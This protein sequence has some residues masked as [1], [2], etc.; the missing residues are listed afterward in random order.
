MVFVCP[1]DVEKMLV[2]GARSVYWKKWAAKHEYEELREG[3]LLY[4]GLTLLRKKVKEN[5]TEKHRNVA[6][7]IFFGRRLDPKEIIR[8]WLVGC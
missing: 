7:K 2:Q 4:P 6:R 3:A 8:H 1:K 5:W